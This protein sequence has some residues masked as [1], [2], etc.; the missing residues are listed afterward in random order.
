MHLIFLALISL[1]LS[2]KVAVTPVLYLGAII[3]SGFGARDNRAQ[4]V[5]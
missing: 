3:P 2:S 4:L 1:T 5:A